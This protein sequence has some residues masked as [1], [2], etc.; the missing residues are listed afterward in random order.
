MIVMGERNAAARVLAHA[1][2]RGVG[3]RV[4]LAGADTDRQSCYGA[5]DVLVLPSL[6]DPSPHVAF[7]AMA[8]TL[9]VIASTK[10]G[11]AELLRSATPASSIRQATRRD[12]P[13]TCRRLS[14]PRLARASGATRAAQCCR[15]R[16]PRSR[17]SRCS[18]IRDLLASPAP[19]TAIAVDT[20]DP[21]HDLPHHSP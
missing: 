19:G 15:F 13:R 8:S 10:S 21:I 3:D 12:S 9:P 5:A 16:R 1:H 4:T 6:Y 7:E 18:F 20:R 11:A 14:I 17:C 2:K